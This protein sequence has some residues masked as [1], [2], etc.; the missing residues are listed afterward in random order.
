MARKKTTGTLVKQASDLLQLLVRVKAADENG[1][2]SCVVCGVRRH[3]KDRMD[4]GH[5]ISRARAA[6]RLVEENV[7]PECKGCNMPGSGHEAGYARY[8]VETYGVELVDWLHNESRK[9]VK[10]NRLELEERIEELKAQIKDA[11]SKTVNTF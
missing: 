9:V 5:F 8:M 1:Y 11:E 10:W 6:T 7:H 4:G 3:Y 2:V